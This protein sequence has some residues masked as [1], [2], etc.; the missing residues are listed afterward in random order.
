M[1]SGSLGL[2]LLSW[3][4]IAFFVDSSPREFNAY[5]RN[6]RSVAPSAQMPGNPEYNDATLQA[7]LAYFRTFLSKAKS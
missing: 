3:A 4:G 5:V 7:L 2:N 6:P 1:P